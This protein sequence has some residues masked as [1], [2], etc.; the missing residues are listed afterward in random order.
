[1]RRRFALKCAGLAAL[2]AGLAT[3]FPALADLQIIESNVAAYKVGAVVPDE[4]V[5]NLNAGDR[6]QVLILQSKQTKVFE[7]KGSHSVVEP[8]G[9]SRSAAGKKKETK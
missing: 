7:G 2:V 3:A 6:V 8:R 4:T 5:F 9:G 1:M